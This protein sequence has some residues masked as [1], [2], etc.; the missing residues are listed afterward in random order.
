MTVT[1]E[2]L[3]KAM[4]ARGVGQSALARDLGVTQG[5]ISKIMLGR[6]AHSRLTPLIASRLNVSLPW[7]LGE[8]DDPSFEKDGSGLPLSA[9]E[10]RLVG[11]FQ[12]LTA[13][14]QGTLVRVAEALLKPGTVHSPRLDYRTDDK[15]G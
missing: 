15:R 3:T 14:Q 7:L 9:E 8:V 4:E 1:G 13:D 12:K 6:T 2:R 10:E 5:A 11:L